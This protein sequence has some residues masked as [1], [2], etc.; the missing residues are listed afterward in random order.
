VRGDSEQLLPEAFFDLPEVGRLAGEVGAV[1]FAQSGK[2][3]TIMLPKVSNDSLISVK[4][5]KFTNDLHGEDLRI[6]KFGQRTTHS[7]VSV[8]DLV[9]DEAKDADVEGAKLHG[10]SP[11]SLW[12]P[13]NVPVSQL[14][15][16][17][18]E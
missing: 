1:D 16:Q 5:Q 3:L 18:R 7:E 15:E 6:R 13:R 10:K 12:F 2:P 8:F 9:V 11:P 14:E 4:C 17:K